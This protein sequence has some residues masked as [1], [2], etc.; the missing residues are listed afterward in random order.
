MTPEQ[1]ITIGPLAF[2]LDRLVALGLILAFLAG[3]DWIVLRWGSARRYPATLALGA[4]LLAARIGYVWRYRESFA[5]EPA[6]ALQAWLGGWDWIAG[7]SGAA[8]ALMLL[9]RHRHGKVASVALVVSLAFVWWAFSALERP[10]ATKAL[11][12]QIAF[13]MINGKTVSAQDLR[14]Q[15]AVINL[16]ATWCPPCRREL[17]MLVRAAASVPDSRILLVDQGEAPDIVRKFLAAQSLPADAV[18]LDPEGALST[19][20]G[21]QALPTTLFVDSQGMIRKVHLGEISR[22]QLD[23]AIRE[24]RAATP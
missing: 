15:P 8:I 12:P 3:L 7:V 13:G 14:G 10:P 4:G 20:V 24:L 16:W 21:A 11:P 9:I 5:L 22:V 6:V 18:A 17:P 1:I 19:L 23:I 2:A